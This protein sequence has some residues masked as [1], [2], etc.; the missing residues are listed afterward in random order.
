MPRKNWWYV[1]QDWDA[2]SISDD[3][4][5]ISSLG[6]DHVRIQCL[7]PVFQPG[8]DYVS[9]GALDRLS[10][11]LEI[12]DRA[13]LDVEVTVLDGWLSGYSFLP[14][15]VAP[16]KT[17][18]NIFTNNDLIQAEEFLFKTIA[19]RIA[20]QDRFLGFDVGNEINVL[21]DAGGN[22]APIAAADRWASGMLDWVAKLVPGKLHVNGADDGPW[23][24]DAGFSRQ[25]LARSGSATVLHCYAY[26][27]G[28]LKRYRYDDVGSLH[29]LEYMV[30]LAKAFAVE[31]GRLVWVEE[32]G[33]SPEWMPEQ[34]I[35]AYADALIRNAASCGHIW[36]FTWWCSHDID[37]SI[38]GF[39]SLEYTLGV[40]DQKNRVKPAGKALARLADQMRSHPVPEL[41]RSTALVIPDGRFPGAGES[42]GWV[43]G[44]QFM[45]LVGRGTRP[46][47]ILE[48]RVADESYLKSRGIRNLVK[49]RADP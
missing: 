37:P 4:E 2:R 27:T 18:Q 11:L 25:N 35:P 40:L 26:F 8:V 44:S 36:G 39:D 33:A 47:I 28:A 14:A 20:R 1:W 15:W 41:E 9:P 49:L 38:R 43:V 32:F 48:S 16:L 6:M 3:F 23:F 31:P 21:Q 19:E 22:P 13:K 24:S 30:E 7:W 17:G 45:E 34:Y 5:A 46:A 12:A 10:E 42:P 29:L